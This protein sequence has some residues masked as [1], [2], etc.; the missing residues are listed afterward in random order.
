[1]VLSV[2]QLVLQVKTVSMVLQASAENR[3]RT[4]KTASMVLQ[5][6]VE[7]GD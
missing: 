6:S 7:N 2:G 3:V 4:E 5:A 1:M